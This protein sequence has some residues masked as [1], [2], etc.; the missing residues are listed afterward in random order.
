MPSRLLRCTALTALVLLLPIRLEAD[1]MEAET[2]DTSVSTSAAGSAASAGMSASSQALA[3]SLA[4]AIRLGIEH[5]LNVE[6]ERHAPLI[7]YEDSQVAWGAYD[8]ELFADYQH[9]SSET[10]TA[11]VVQSFFAGGA[12]AAAANQVTI[13]RDRIGE[14]NS[15]I[16]GLVPWL[17]ASYGLAYNGKS[18]ESTS[19]FNALFPEY[20]STLLASGS[21][22][23]LKGLVWNQAWTQV[24]TSAYFHESSQE[25]FKTAL[26]DEV[27]DIET[28]YWALVATREQERVAI[29]SLEASRALLDQTET[30]YEVGV[31]SRVEVV[32]AEAGV[33]ER[34]VNLIRASNAYRAAQDRLL[35]LVYGTRLQ[36]DTQVRVNPTDKPEDYIAYEI[37][38]DEAMRKAESNRPELAA[39]RKEVDRNKINLKFAKNQRLPQLDIEGAYGYQ[40]IAGTEK[41]GV[42]PF[43]ALGDDYYATD[44][45]FLSDDG[46]LQW[47][48]KGVFSYPLGNRAGVHGVS[49]SELEL[50]RSKT[51]L[52]QLYQSI[53]LDVRNSARNLDSAQQGI[54]AAERRRIAAEE[55]FRAESIRLEQGES[56]PFDVLQRERDLV[57]AESQ[58]INALQVYRDSVASLHRAQGTILQNHNISVED[59]SSL[60]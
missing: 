52:T 11:N 59:A 49:R 10:P 58:K 14:G 16:R 19:A 35:D 43:V 46:A 45:D 57:D 33:A 21:L 6:V 15:G 29:K 23:L 22:P 47:S 56:T 36:A 28:G 50:R 42:A 51:R 34:D 4:E 1:D 30:Q 24:K 25:N 2:D 60:R 9:S 17:G 39:A 31:V 44:D 55:Q 40:G 5:N 37:D 38:N 32:E 54:E 3:L 26:M 7:A 53:V 13:I 20:R 48:V 12:P 18:T 8:P 41:R 27:R